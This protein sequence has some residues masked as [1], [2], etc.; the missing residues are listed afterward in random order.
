MQLT[1]YNDYA[2]DA[3]G[4]WRAEFLHKAFTVFYN[5]HTI[6]GQIQ[7]GQVEVLSKTNAEKRAKL[8]KEPI[9][10][11]GPLATYNAIEIDAENAEAAAAAAVHLYGANATEGELRVCETS[12]LESKPGV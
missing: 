8:G 3:V 12:V 1:S 4:L 10:V 6:P 11:T 9:L 7:D 2:E 5:K